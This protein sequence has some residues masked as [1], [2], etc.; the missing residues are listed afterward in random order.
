[1]APGSIPADYDSYLL[2][3]FRAGS[4]QISLL[5]DLGVLSGENQRVGESAPVALE[6][7]EFLIR[8][9]P[10][11]SVSALGIA[12][13]GT[14]K[15]D[16]LAWSLAAER[17]WNALSA[18]FID[19]TVVSLG[20]FNDPFGFHTGK[21]VVTE[22]GGPVDCEA[23]GFTQSHAGRYLLTLGN[24]TGQRASEWGPPGSIGC[25]S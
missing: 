14:V 1:M 17:G 9:S 16:S 8:N 4:Y 19:A 7:R 13:R 22:P 15:T 25:C 11:G 21:F 18:T 2:D 23:L 20:T 6:I 10:T 3:A 5:P 12:S 24:P